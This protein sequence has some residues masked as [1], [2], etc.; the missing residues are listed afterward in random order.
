MVELL[1]R[2]ERVVAR[3]VQ[4]HAVE[5][6]R[7]TAVVEATDEQLAA[8]RTERVVVLEAD[9]RHQVDDIV[10]RLAG[11]LVRNDRLVE[12]LLGLGRVGQLDAID[13][14]GGMGADDDGLL[15]EIDRAGRL[16]HGGRGDEGHAKRQRSAGV[17]IRAVH[18]CPR[19]NVVAGASQQPMEATAL[20]PHPSRGQ[21][22]ARRWC[23][24]PGGFP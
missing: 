21:E 4:R 18:W 22:T 16:G 2:V 15:F 14:L 13:R 7:D 3:V 1:V 8:G 12:D 11:G 9:A 24:P 19:C 20:Q 5:R 10:D 23:Q 17:E 6:L